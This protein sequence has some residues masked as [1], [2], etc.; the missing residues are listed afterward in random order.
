MVAQ[1]IQRMK[2][3]Q[4]NIWQGRLLRQV[5]EFLRKERP[6][7]V[8]MQ[9]VYSS[10]IDNSSQDFLRS[11]ER[12][13]ALFPN[14]HG[15]FSARYDLPVLDEKARYGIGMLSRFPITDTETLFVVGSRKSFATAAELAAHQGQK[16]PCNLQRVIVR[17]DSDT[18]FCLINH[19]GYWEPNGMGTD[20]NVRAMEKVGEIVRNSPR[21]LI[22]AG[23]LNVVFESPAMKPIQA[24]LN[25]LTQAYRLPTTLSEFG[26]VSNVACDHICVSDGID[27]HSFHASDALVSDHMP[28]VMEFNLT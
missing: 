7:F 2:I 26:K 20:A 12:I 27:V 9:E 13:Q 4:L 18:S 23:D 1:G 28:L 21:P 3:V 11:F 19:H 14:Y 8:C 17:I 15:Y 16:E 6:D 25:D 5:L 24:Q 22:L 10:K